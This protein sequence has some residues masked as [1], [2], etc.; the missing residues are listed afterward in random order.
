MAVSTDR[1]EHRLLAGLKKSATGIPG[2]DEITGG[3]LPAGRTTLVCG[4]AGS[5]KT[6]LSLQFLVYGAAEVLLK[7]VGSAGVS[8]SGA[9]T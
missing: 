8:C 4:T 6:L 3:G 2:L 9:S 7:D 5:G 1:T